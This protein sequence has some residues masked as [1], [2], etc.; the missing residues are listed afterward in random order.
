MLNLK[1]KNEKKELIKAT[2]ETFIVAFFYSVLFI[3]VINILFG[4]FIKDITSYLNLITIKTTEEKL[5]DVNLDSTKSNLTNYPEYGMRYATISIPSLSI[6]LPVYYGDTSSI[7]KLG[8]GHSSGSYFPGEGGSI[9][10]MGHNTKNM[11][12]EL[13]NIE[14]NSIITIETTYGT[15]NYKVYNSK[16]INY[17]ETEEVPI[18]REEEV[19][20]LYTCYES[21]RFGHTEK[22][23]VV[24]ARLESKELK[25]DNNE[26]NN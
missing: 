3:I 4:G 2:I 13:K 1:E 25:G 16:V 11:L 24:Y 26:K 14:N 6:N 7:L 12:K 17:K 9:L 23:F 10:Y 22:R 21:L 8:V 18:E 15:F 5:K 20:M 19:L